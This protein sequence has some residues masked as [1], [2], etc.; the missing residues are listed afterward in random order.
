MKYVDANF[1]IRL[2]TNDVPKL[3][4]QAYQ[5]IEESGSE[6]IVLLDAV[7]TEV[8]FVLANHAS[9]KLKR[10]TIHAGLSLVINTS[11]ILV[12]DHTGQALEFYATYPGLDYVDCLLLARA[13][14]QKGKILSFDKALLKHAS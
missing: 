13:G 5:M 7:I 4:E 10:H 14:R 11:N 1:I 2:I 3:A 12:S 9:Y 6:E 8:S